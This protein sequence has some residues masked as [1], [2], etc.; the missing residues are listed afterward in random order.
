MAVQCGTMQ[1]SMGKPTQEWHVITTDDKLLNSVGLG[2]FTTGQLYE[3]CRLNHKDPRFATSMPQPAIPVPGQPPI[4]ATTAYSLSDT[5]DLFLHMMGGLYAEAWSHLWNEELKKYENVTV[6]GNST[7]RYASLGSRQFA[8]L[9]A[10]DAGRVAAGAAGI[11]STFNPALLVPPPMVDY[12]IAGAVPSHYRAP[13]NL[14]AMNHNY[15][16][17]KISTLS[18]SLKYL[19][20]V[21]AS[22]EGNCWWESE[23][24]FNTHSATGAGCW[25]KVEPKFKLYLFDQNYYNDNSRTLVHRGSPSYVALPETPHGLEYSMTRTEEAGNKPGYFYRPEGGGDNNPRNVVAGDLDTYYEANTGKFEAGT[26]QI[27]ARMLT[28]LE[29]VVINPL[30]VDEVNK[31]TQDDVF[32]IDSEFYMG[33]HNVGIAMPV[34]VQHG[35]PHHF[36]PVWTDPECSPGQKETITVINRSTDG[37][38]AGDLVLCTKIGGEWVVQEFGKA[39]SLVK[40]GIE[41]WGSLTNLISDNDSYFKDGRYYEAGVRPW[42]SV[43]NAFPPQQVPYVNPYGA[44]VSAEA[45]ES[46]T[47]E[48]FW[49]DLGG[50]TFSAWAE[51]DLPKIRL[52]NMGLPPAGTPVRPDFEAARRGYWQMTSF[53]L[54]SAIIGGKHSHSVMGRTNMSHQQDGLVGE[55]RPNARAFYPFWG[56]TFENG[57]D[58]EKLGKLRNDPTMGLIPMGGASTGPGGGFPGGGGGSTS[59]MFLSPYAGGSAPMAA[60]GGLPADLSIGHTASI[61]GTDL[62]RQEYGGIFSMID[63]VETYH[64]P[65]VGPSLPGTPNINQG[66]YSYNHVRYTTAYDV[67]E[68]VALQLPADVA[69]NSSPSGQHG[70]PIEDIS[71]ISFQAGGGGLINGAK[72]S[73]GSQ[74]YVWLEARAP[75]VPV[76]STL[77]VPAIPGNWAF[78]AIPAIPAV[79]AV[80]DTTAALASGSLGYNENDKDLSVFDLKPINK[81][82]ITFLPLTAELVASRD[83]IAQTTSGPIPGLQVGNDKDHYTRSSNSINLFSTDQ[84][85]SLP[86][87]AGDNVI[88]DSWFKRNQDLTGP[89]TAG[90][91]FDVGGGVPAQT[92]G[93]FI[94][95]ALV[96]ASNPPISCQ[97]SFAMGRQ[98]DCEACGGTWGQLPQGHGVVGGNSL[99]GGG[100]LKIATD[101][102]YLVPPWGTLGWVGSTSYSPQQ[103]G[104]SVNGIPY[105]WHVM[106]KFLYRN[107]AANMWGSDTASGGDVVGVTTAKA[108]ITA[109][110]TS[111]R[112]E[113][114]NLFGMPP[115]SKATN[116]NDW[117]I[118]TIGGI[119]GAIL[120][121]YGTGGGSVTTSTQPQWGNGSDN[122]YDLGTTALWAKLYDAWPNDQTV[123][124]PRYF[125][126]FHFNPG[127]LGSTPVGTQVYTGI[128]GFQPGLGAGVWDLWTAGEAIP[129]IWERMQATPTESVDFRIPTQWRLDYS[130]PGVVAEPVPYGAIIDGSWV[131]GNY[132]PATG[133]ISTLGTAPGDVFMAPVSDWKINPI[134]RGMLL[135]FI[136]YMRTVGLNPDPAALDIIEGGLD[137]AVGDY[138]T[139]V[140]GG[141]QGAKAKVSSV[142]GAGAITA[143]EFVQEAAIKQLG[144]GYSA[145]DFPDPNIPGTVVQHI[146]NM[147]KLD[148]AGMGAK[149]GAIQGIV[150]E[151][152]LK[153]EG[154]QQKGS[155]I[156]L[157]PNSNSGRGS[158]DS[159]APDSQMKGYVTAGAIG[160]LPLENP[161]PDDKYD[162]FLH[163]HSDISHTFSTASTW[164]PAH[165]QFVRLTVSAQ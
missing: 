57:Y 120:P 97:P 126:V 54:L 7:N 25:T 142:S 101:G 109:A 127:E 53:D 24:Y 102:Q 154:P 129:T 11:G 1:G 12:M 32:L 50:A 76:I 49:Y 95:N 62:D 20:L 13:L 79:D 66:S 31:L 89:S 61:F 52:I 27:L 3:F 128:D 106:H 15:V 65:A 36:G 74:R 147:V 33:S 140:G 73:L 134:R 70:G 96:S 59:S 48:Q 87:K 8:D 160:E 43:P 39:G 69:L 72:S 82:Q 143:L 45:Y 113:T 81:A 157:T 119:G 138:V 165:Q 123:F 42:A 21:K 63:R 117:E 135:P 152:P 159:S 118:T 16:E 17:G 19:N 23:I 112:L 141:G 64:P 41:N 26:R 163:Y 130:V 68:K 90:M 108:K 85:T 91:S 107:G 158:T 56:A 150:Y 58:P 5:N 37:F 88:H 67:V 164:N 10:G 146:V 14:I 44:V 94:G 60:G 131:N 4:P 148:G 77:A 80:T 155:A 83:K 78:P 28:T 151:L 136:Y 137:Y 144:F 100:E 104:A 98:A 84:P 121:G 116:G 115:L 75:G 162:L 38:Y 103:R 6:G 110:G 71:K 29:P 2:V 114:A 139:F 18:S 161:P 9:A 22:R 122:Y 124:D 133:G 30:A 86:N 99:S 125:A 132:D 105:N 156:R 153:D 40:F 34:A 35:N 145:L 46:A 93:C 55:D 111:I 149:I 92:Q 47:R 51:N